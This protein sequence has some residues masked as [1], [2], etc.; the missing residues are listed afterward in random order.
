MAAKKVAAK[1]KRKT[2]AKKV[3]RKVS[4]ATPRGMAKRYGHLYLDPPID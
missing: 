1:P 4:A 3:S 2:A